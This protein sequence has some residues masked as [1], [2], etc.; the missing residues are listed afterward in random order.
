[1]TRK[2]ILIVIITVFILL[3]LYTGIAKLVNYQHFLEGFESS[4]LLR[5]FAHMPVWWVPV[6]EVL[7]PIL[8]LSKKYRL[9]GLYICFII[10]ILFTA[11]IVVLNYHSEDIPCDC[12]G[13]LEK[14]SPG[15]HIFLNCL[16]AA[17][18]LGGITLEKK[19]RNEND[20]K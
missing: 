17:L 15:L 14:L 8:L 2:K 13:Y 5:P 20:Y 3:F 7:L 19:L 9:F 6:A 11:Y 4:F 18:A 12:G 16:L 10:M 1:M